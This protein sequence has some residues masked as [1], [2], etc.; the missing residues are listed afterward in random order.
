MAI[1][2]PLDTNQFKHYLKF[3]SVGSADLYQITEPIGF[4]GANFVKKQESKRYA[5]SV[6][7]GS[8]DKMKFADII[9]EEIDTPQIINPQGDQSYNLD[10]GLEWLLYIYKTYG[11]EGKVEYILEKGGVKFSGGMLDFTDKDITDGYTYIECKLIQK[12]KVADL[13]RR[14]ED[15]FNA[16]SDKNAKQETI[17]TAPTV[18][19][20]LK[21]TPIISVSSWR[22]TNTPFNLVGAGNA[23]SP[24]RQIERSDIKNTLTLFDD[25]IQW[26][27]TGTNPFTNFA[28]INNKK[29]LTDVTVN[30]KIKGLAT[31][32]GGSL[33]NKI[34]LYLFHCNPS[35]FQAN[36]SAAQNIYEIDLTTQTTVNFEAEITKTFSNIPI[37]DKIYSMFYYSRISG[38]GNITITFEDSTFEIK[39]S[40]TS[41]DTVVKGVRWIDLIKQASKFTSAIPVNAPLFD[42]GGEHYDNLVFNRR[43]ISQNVDNFYST[44][45]TVFES[46]EEV[47]CDYE[48][49][50]NVIFIGHQRDYYKN[51]EIGDFLII[52]SEDFSISENDRCMINKF[53]YKYKTFEQDRLSKGTDQGI[54]TDSEFTILNENVENVKEINIDFVRDPLAIQKIVDL[55][56]NEPTTS[57]D[58]DDKVYISNIV[59]LAPGSFAQWTARLLL[60]VAN[61]KLEIL[62]RDSEGDSSDVFIN[63]TVLGFGVNS[64]FFITGGNNQGEYKVTA[65]T[66]TILTLTPVGFT[67]TFNG[68]SIITV[69]YTYT[70]VLY[71][72][73]KGE[74]FLEGKFPNQNYS[75]KRNIKHYGEYL[76]SCLLYSRKD[77]VSAYFK[78]NGLYESKKSGETVTLIENAPITYDSLP[79]PLTTAKMFEVKCVAEFEDVLKLL[80]NYQVN[81]GFIRL[82]DSNE[83]VL[84]G[85]IQKLDHGWSEN[86]LKMTIEEKFETEFLELTYAND[87]LIVSDVV[88]NLGGNSEWWKMENDFLKLYDAQSRPISNYYRYNFVRLNSVIYNT[89]EELINA[90][91]NL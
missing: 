75:I 19:F 36:W 86:M 14:L 89:K 4:D 37:G 55:E 28:Y 91:V 38:G 31:R 6:E 40:A 65:I 77:I 90:L 7:Y 71:T 56:V 59:S 35:N 5:R 81:R 45:K 2:N 16:F 53:K 67:P 50:E 70:N 46:V 32:S 10:L 25:K 43:M 64:T 8:I 47:N 11:F 17:T 1:N 79:S 13:K 3:I 33:E 84:K 80:E 34:R 48:P 42:V 61:G 66:K 12:N 22:S 30:F 62:N 49:N 15:K 39:G 83:R 60:R 58:D 18:D 21:A 57:T 88:Y 20:L 51:N 52:P 54:H 76:K 74:G 29:L 26:N 87:V 63:W 73:R 27:G 69:K 24:F 44:P 78:S 41:I 82:Y 9:G 85:Y 23:F 72:S 68:D